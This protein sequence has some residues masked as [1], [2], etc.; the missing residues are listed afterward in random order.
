MRKTRKKKVRFAKKLTKTHYIRKSYYKRGGGWPWSRG[1]GK[2]Y[3]KKKDKK[4]DKKTK[5]KKG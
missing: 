2:K 3:I 4:K 5:K 1:K